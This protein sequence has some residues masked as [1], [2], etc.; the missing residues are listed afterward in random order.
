MG[1]CVYGVGLGLYLLLSGSS[2]GAALGESVVGIMCR[3]FWL[4]LALD[5]VSFPLFVPRL[6]HIF[7]FCVESECN[8][9]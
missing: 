7:L 8:D 4:I 2:D 9:I 5:I 6:L 1:P 3:L